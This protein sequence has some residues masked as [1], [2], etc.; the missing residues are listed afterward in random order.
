M[1]EP[2]SSRLAAAAEAVQVVAAVGKPEG[3]EIGPARLYL[4]SMAAPP[5][6]TRSSRRLRSPKRTGASG[7]S[8]GRCC[9]QSKFVWAHWDGTD[10]TEKVVKSET[11]A[12][13][14][15]LPLE[16]EGPEAEP[17]ECVK[18]GAASAR[19]VLFAKNY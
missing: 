6:S 7:Y 19:R 8:T 5:P 11:K 13:V 10:E 12:T 9:A 1:S 3:A 17:G 15:C 2:S 14:R 16:G 18:T 4:H